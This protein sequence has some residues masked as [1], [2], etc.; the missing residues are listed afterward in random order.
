VQAAGFKKNQR[1][2][3]KGTVPKDYQEEDFAL[4]Q[5]LVFYELV[6]IVRWCQKHGLSYTNKQLEKSREIQHR[7]SQVAN[8][9]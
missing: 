3:F 9:L 4:N 5:S 1:P 6:S 2:G 7:F 8:I